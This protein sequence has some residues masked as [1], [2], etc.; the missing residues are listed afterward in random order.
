[1]TQKYARM[2][3]A[4]ALL[5]WRLKPQNNRKCF[6]TINL[7]LSVDSYIAIFYFKVSQYAHMETVLLME[8]LLAVILC[9]IL[10]YTKIVEIFEIFARGERV[11]WEI[12]N[13][14]QASNT[15]INQSMHVTELSFT[16]SGR[17]DHIWTF[18][19]SVYISSAIL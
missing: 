8:F 18:Q 3:D 2:P 12:N 11:K 19:Q 10:R 13:N 15:F 9:G 14:K 17:F 16:L 4:W 7:S 5:S 6:Q 1:M